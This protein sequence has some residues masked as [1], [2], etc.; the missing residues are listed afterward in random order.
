M[1]SVYKHLRIIP[2]VCNFPKALWKVKQDLQIVMLENYF[3]TF[4]KHNLESLLSKSDQRFWLIQNR[5]NRRLSSKQSTHR[6]L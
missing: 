2:N 1:L 6:T 3:E 5:T 4:F